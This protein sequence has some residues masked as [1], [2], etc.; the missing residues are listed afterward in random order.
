MVIWIWILQ[1]D[2][3]NQWDSKSVSFVLNGSRLME[4]HSFKDNA[5]IHHGVL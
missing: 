1:M 2:S 3:M 5:K 4:I